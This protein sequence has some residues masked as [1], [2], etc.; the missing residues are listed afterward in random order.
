VAPL[1]AHISVSELAAR[2]AQLLRLY[3][4]RDVFPSKL[5]GYDHRIELTPGAVQS[6][7]RGRCLNSVCDL[8]LSHTRLCS[9]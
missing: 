7:G 8:L 6:S 1:L 4:F 3:V 2:A 5:P 9:V